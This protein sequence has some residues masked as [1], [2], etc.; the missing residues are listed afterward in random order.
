MDTKTKS[1]KAEDLSGDLFAESG[2][3]GTGTPARVPMHLPRV[4]GGARSV[5]PRV[6]TCPEG[7]GCDHVS[8]AGVRVADKT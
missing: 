5:T 1:P 8:A 7:S 6:G 3:G 2:S 4:R